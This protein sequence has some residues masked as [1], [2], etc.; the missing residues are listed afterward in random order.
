MFIEIKIG[1][2]MN[3]YGR[4]LS[5]A[6]G[7]LGWIILWYFTL[8]G[9]LHEGIV[10]LDFTKYNELWIEFIVFIIIIII[11]FISWIWDEVKN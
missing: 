6:L 4:R 1:D 11:I 10:I 8:M 9:L 7:I 2:K 3:N 5:Y